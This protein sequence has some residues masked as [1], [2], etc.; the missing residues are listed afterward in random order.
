M[1]VTHPAGIKIELALI[2]AL[3]FKTVFFFFFL[4]LVAS[5][6][7]INSRVS[8]SFRRGFVRK[9]EEEEPTMT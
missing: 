8:E 5:D 9:K 1:I 6:T 7:Q 4:A 2:S 3:V